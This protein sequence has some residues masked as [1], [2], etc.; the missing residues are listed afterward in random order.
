M[1]RSPSLQRGGWWWAGGRLSRE[2]TGTVTVLE[3]TCGRAANEGGLEDQKETWKPQ[4]TPNLYLSTRITATGIWKGVPDLYKVKSH[5]LGESVMDL[6]QLVSLL[7][8][9]EY[10]LA[11]ETPVAPK[12][13][14]FVG[15]TCF[16]QASMGSFEVSPGAKQPFQKDSFSNAHEEGWMLARLAPF[17]SSSVAIQVERRWPSDTVP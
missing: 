10:I 3:C 17:C 6:I 12:A 7:P 13:L 2:G 11:P 8:N 1:K 16:S 5:I 14:Q 15:A 9:I 4:V